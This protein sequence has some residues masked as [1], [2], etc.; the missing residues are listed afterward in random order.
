MSAV[1]LYWD[2]D[3]GGASLE[4]PDEGQKQ[5]GAWDGQTTSFRIHVDRWVRFYSY[6]N[7]RGEN[8]EF[9][10]PTEVADLSHY[11]HGF[12][13]TGNWNDEVASVEVL[14]A[15]YRP[16][17]IDRGGPPI[18]SH[19]TTVVHDDYL[20]KA[21]VTR[22]PRTRPSPPRAKRKADKKKKR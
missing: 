22:H 5:L 19:I 1:T 4:I 10:G 11:A 16:A 15:D 3:F 6:D 21:L 18:R 9:R 8:I 12:M 13:N 2:K 7:W 17:E 20:L 14:P